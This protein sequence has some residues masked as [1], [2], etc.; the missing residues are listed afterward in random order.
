ML[1]FPKMSSGVDSREAAS[2]RAIAIRFIGA[3]QEGML[4]VGHGALRNCTVV[5]G[6][7]S[8]NA[9]VR[10]RVINQRSIMR[11]TAK[12]RAEIIEH[13]EKALTLCEQA[14][15]PIVGYLIERALD[16]ARASH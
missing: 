9:S 2:S 10:R 7:R 15:E 16:E 4:R 5:S 14:S 13:L 1:S 3:L 11:D 8:H 6:G 12:Y